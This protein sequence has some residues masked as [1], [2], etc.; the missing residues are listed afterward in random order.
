MGNKMGNTMFSICGGQSRNRTGDTGI[1]NPVLY[2]LS[3][4]PLIFTK[5]G[6]FVNCIY[7]A[8]TFSDALFINLILS[9]SNCNFNSSAL[10]NRA[11][12]LNL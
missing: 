12:S 6:Q 11:S 9:R 3:Y 5:K 2:Q 7:S 10:S 4:L 1:F 8:K